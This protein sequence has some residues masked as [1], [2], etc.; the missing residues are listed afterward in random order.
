MNHVPWTEIDNFHTVRKTLM[1]Y[2]HLLGESGSNV[3]YRAKV[4]LHGTNAGVKVS[5]DGTVAAMSRTEMITPEADNHGFAR[6][7]ASDARAAKFRECALTDLDICIYGEWCGPGIQKGVAVCAL[8]EKIFAVFAV[9]ILNDEGT[10]S[11]ITEPASL[12]G[13]LDD[14]PGVH[15]IPWFEDGTSVTVDWSAEAETLA[16]V[17]DQVNK[18][19][20]AVEECDPW[21]EQTF[22]IKGVG[23]GLV[24]YPESASYKLFKNVCFKAKGD[25][26]KTVAHT[27]PA[28]ADPTVVASLEAFAELVITEARCEQGVRLL[29]AGELI[30]DMGH[31]GAFLKW[32]GVDVAKETQF[33]LEAS[34]LD[35]KLAAKACSTRAREW[36]IPQ[37]KKL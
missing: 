34:G 10:A 35:P 25:K 12:K 18:W 32:I 36:F 17:I 24:F 27:K 21:I 7:L 14:I 31:I 3:R 9:R 16:P 28:Q 15:I 4:K 22:G 37:A 30:F 19:V 13:F 29:N 26:H 2:P 8:P 5:R 11:F 6:W 23:E 1:T 33:E 20:M